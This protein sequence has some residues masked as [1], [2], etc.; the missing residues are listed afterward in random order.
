MTV[1]PFL[2]LLGVAIGLLHGT[3]LLLQPLRKVA[4]L[5]LLLLLLLLTFRQFV[6]LGGRLLALCHE[7]LGLFRDRG[8]RARLL[9]GR[10]AFAEALR[11]FLDGLLVANVVPGRVVALG[12]IRH[13]QKAAGRTLR[14]PQLDHFCRDLQ[15]AVARESHVVVLVLVDQQAELD[16]AGVVGGVSSS[17]AQAVY[18]IDNIYCIG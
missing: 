17:S 16:V 13:G 15:L 14:P 10:N 4:L 18:S 12:G 2:L 8:Q 5:L 3:L 1:I 6:E 11:G 7:R 9:V